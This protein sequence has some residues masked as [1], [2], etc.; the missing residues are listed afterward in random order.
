MNGLTPR[1]I[2]FGIGF[3][4]M[5]VMA[6]IVG[7]LILRKDVKYW[8]NRFF[9]SAFFFFAAAVSLILIYLFSYDP[10]VIAFLNYLSFCNINATPICLLLGIL[11]IYKGEDEVMQNK[12][13]YLFILIMIIIMVIHGLIP[14]GVRVEFSLPKWSILFGLYEII[15]G[16]AIFVSVV[17]FSI[18]LYRELSVEMQKKLKLF[19]T[20]LVTSNISI[21]SVVIKNMDII[22]G[23]QLIESIFGVGSLIS[24]IFV[25]IFSV[26]TLISFIF[27]YFGI[28][29]RQ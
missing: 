17:Y 2:N 16:Q 6:I 3:L 25:G 5:I 7:L 26:G 8:G 22:G 24:F 9:A 12:S 11:V 18:K 23:V 28:V 14:E 10:F 27:I 19:I 1:Q 13:T 15:F 21:T 4:I 20:G 29:R